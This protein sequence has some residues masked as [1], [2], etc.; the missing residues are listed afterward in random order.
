LMDNITLIAIAV[1]LV[2]ALGA[3]LWIRS[4]SGDRSLD[5]KSSN[6]MAR[7]AASL[8]AA[9]RGA[10]SSGVDEST[11]DE[12]EEALIASDLGV[13]VAKGIVGSLRSSRPETPAEA[14][15]ELRAGLISQMQRSDRALHIEGTPAVV[16]VVGVNGTGKT[17]SIAKLAMRLK[18]E[19]RSVM[20]AAA[21]TFRAAGGEQLRTW[22]DRVGVPVV[23]GQEGGDPASVAFDAISSATA[24]G[25][26]I[27]LLDTA[28]RLHGKKNLMAELV[29]I[30]KV[31]S[32]EATVSETL[33][34]LD[35]TA[36]QNGIVQVKEFADT[37]PITGIILTKLDGTAKGGIVVAVE[38][39]LDV[40]VKFV[41]LGEGLSHLEPFDPVSFV[42][43]LLEE[44]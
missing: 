22:G 2:I 3:V 11:W 39:Q 31:A 29:K 42:D 23:A 9:L 16:L 27:V 32:R 7:S 20:L 43:A 26:E 15:T 13:G 8:G 19:D 35:A 21:D 37:V 40:P 33:L 4:R 18:D 10:W 1:A 5:D 17:T 14:R 30:H 12:I 44:S 41:G 25:I 6:R 36:G 24:K 38:D 34:V 28:G